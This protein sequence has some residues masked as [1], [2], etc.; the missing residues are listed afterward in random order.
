MASEDSAP[1]LVQPSPFA[2]VPQLFPFAL[3]LPAW[4]FQ[5]PSVPTLPSELSGSFLLPELPPYQ[6]A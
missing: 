1:W 2:G 6:A 4:L 5:Q 3:P